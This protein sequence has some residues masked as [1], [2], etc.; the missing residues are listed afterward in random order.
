MYLQKVLG[1]KFT[2]NLRMCWILNKDFQ[3]SNFQS[4]LCNQAFK[5]FV[6]TRYRY[7]TNIF[8]A[9]AKPCKLSLVKTKKYLLSVQGHKY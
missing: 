9:Y 5:I 2:A 4:L 1:Q 7:L 3:A 8:G 6:A